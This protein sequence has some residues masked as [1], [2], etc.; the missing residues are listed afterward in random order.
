[1]D[2]DDIVLAPWTT[3]KYRVSGTT[4]VNV[5]Q[6]SPTALETAQRI[7]TLN[8]RYP[9]SQ[10]LYPIPS[11]I[12]M[13]DTPQP[14]R[15]TTVDQILV[16]ATSAQEIPRSIRQMTELLREWHRLRAGQEDNFSIRDMTEITKAMASTSQ[17]I[18][19]LLLAVAFISLLVGGAAWGCWSERENER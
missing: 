12:Q 11:G 7:N 4:L 13:A 9:G 15:F 16:K 1:M 2:Q 8:E 10:P 18:G 19:S 14:V 6:S 3:I 5:N 17:L